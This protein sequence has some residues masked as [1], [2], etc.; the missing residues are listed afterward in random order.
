M[1]E[2]YWGLWHI[3]DPT[4]GLSPLE[5]NAVVFLQLI[6]ATFS[7]VSCVVV[8]A[9][10]L[11]FR[12]KILNKRM[13]RF[14]LIL[15]SSQ[16]MYT[17]AFVFPNDSPSFCLFQSIGIQVS[18]NLSMLW[19]LI[20][21]FEVLISII[22]AYFIMRNKKSL[23]TEMIYHVI[24]WTATAIFALVP[25]ITRSYGYS[26]IW[27]WID[28]TTL[29]KKLRFGTFYIPLWI[30][31]FLMMTFYIVVIYLYKKTKNQ[32]RESLF[33]SPTENDIL[34]NLRQENKIIRMMIFPAI[35][36]ITWIPPTIQRVYQYFTND[37]IT[38]LF[39]LEVILSGFRGFLDSV[40]YAR[41]ANIRLNSCCNKNEK[42]ELQLHNNVIR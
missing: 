19:S 12:K 14:I 31:M 23:W 11:M 20:I 8:I 39:F 1:S 40:A 33:N 13:N 35:A 38:W 5:L 21:S 7:I 2:N 18:Q 4:L 32:L 10:L 30:S 17:V 6:C 36:F 37:T 26:G 34:L 27:C 9:Y 16:L 41:L 15:V 24:A 3:N 42:L 29:G 22:R 25:G 28:D